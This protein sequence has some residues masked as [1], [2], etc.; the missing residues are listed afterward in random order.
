M[1][2][3]KNMMKGLRSL[4]LTTANGYVKITKELAH[5]FDDELNE[6]FCYLYRLEQFTNNEYKEMYL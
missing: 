6:H 5:Y 4:K 1:K 3:I 2:K